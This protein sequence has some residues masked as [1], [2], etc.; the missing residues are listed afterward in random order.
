MQALET[1]REDMQCEAERLLAFAKAEE[2][3]QVAV[4]ERR[5]EALETLI[6][7]LRKQ[8]ELVNEAEDRR[9]NSFALLKAELG[10]PANIGFLRLLPMIPED[11]RQSLSESYRQL[12][13]AVYAVKAATLRLNYYF[14][15]VSETLQKILQELLPHRKGK[16][17]APNG[18]TAEP[19]V[20]NLIVNHSL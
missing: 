4:S 8:S 15:S 12:K 1:F 20:D 7:K 13:V 5:W 14:Q 19:L 18:K 6:L 11:K 10:L 3:I 9:F 2:E 16:L 17:Y